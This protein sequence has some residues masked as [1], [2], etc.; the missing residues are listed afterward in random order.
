MRA[1][2]Q[3]VSQAQVTVDS[4]ITGAISRGLLVLLGVGQGDSD[5]DLNYVVK[6]TVNLRVFEDEH[7]KM[8]LSVKD[9]GGKLL[10]VSQFTLLGDVTQGNR[11]SFISAAV[12]EVA[13]QMYGSFVRLSREQGVEV[14]TGVFRA[15]MQVQLVNDGPVTILIDS[16]QR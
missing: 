3:R 15:H 2:I 8:N 11:P 10:V 14:E 13:N 9:V 4:E 6:K 7:G 16:R 5:I 12:P 1:V